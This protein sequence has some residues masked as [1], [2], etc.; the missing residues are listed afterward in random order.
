MEVIKNRL[1]VKG[2]PLI[3]AQKND[4]MDL[5]IYTTPECSWCKELKVW[6]NHAILFSLNFTRIGWPKMFWKTGR[7]LSSNGM[8]KNRRSI[9]KIAKLTT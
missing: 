8:K 4:I 1:N 7:N 2:R 3:E 6:L 5:K 9:I